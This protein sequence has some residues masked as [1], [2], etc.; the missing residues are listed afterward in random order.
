MLGVL[1]LFV[2][3]LVVGG[4]LMELSGRRVYANVRQVSDVLITEKTVYSLYIDMETATRGFLITGDEEGP[5]VNGTVK[6]LE[7]ARD[8]G[9]RFDHCIL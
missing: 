8:R 1:I 6:L 2:A 4:I 7:W 5:A 3:A 9:E